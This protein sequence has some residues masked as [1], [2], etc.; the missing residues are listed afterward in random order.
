VWHGGQKGE[1]ALLASC[2][3]A[4][5]ELALQNSVH[6]IAFPGLSTGAY[7]YPKQQATRIAI[8][9]MREYEEKFEE[10]ICCCFSEEDKKIYE[11]AVASSE[12]N[13]RKP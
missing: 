12:E 3:R 1:P 8:G 10:I 11:E 2:Y 13:N 7:G 5:L 6:A 4:A 9:V